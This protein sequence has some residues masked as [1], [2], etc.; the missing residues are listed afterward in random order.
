MVRKTYKTRIKYKRDGRGKTNKRLWRRTGPRKRKH[1][2]HTKK[3]KGGII[4]ISKM[5]D[6]RR[7]QGIPPPGLDFLGRSSYDEQVRR[8]RVLSIPSP[9][10]R[11]SR[12]LLRNNPVALVAERE[13]TWR[14]EL[15]AQ[16]QAQA[17]SHARAQERDRIAAFSQAQNPGQARAQAA[18]EQAQIARAEML[19][20]R[21]AEQER[22]AYQDEFGREVDKHGVRINV[23]SDLPAIRK[24]R[25]VKIIGPPGS[26]YM[27]DIG[28]IMHTPWRERKRGSYCI[29]LHKNDGR[30]YLKADREDIEAIT[31]AVAKREYKNRTGETQLPRA[32]PDVPSSC[33]RVY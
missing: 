14:H 27:G 15:E 3:R 30:N 24:G 4:N 26:P 22:F 11:V 19:R 10:Q 7:M 6:D 20:R 25:F 21:E 31:A 2:R 8:D 5:I 28:K 1:K 9:T 32:N 16:A 13:R 23:E 17:R 18:L 33:P 12:P 29:H